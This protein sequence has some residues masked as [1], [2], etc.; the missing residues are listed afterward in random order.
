MIVDCHAHIGIPMTGTRQPL[1]YGKVLNKGRVEQWL[2]PSF[3]PTGSPPE[4][5][6]G[7]MDQAGV[8]RA[9]LVQ[10]QAY[11]DQNALVLDSIRRWPDRF[12]GFAYLGPLDRPEAPDRLERLIEAGMSGLKVIAMATR[13]QQPDFRFDGERE[14]RVWERLDRLKC[15]LVIDAMFAPAEDTE[16]IRKMVEEFG[17]LRILICHLGGPGQE[18]WQDRAMLAKHPRIW[19]DL[20]SIPGRPDPKEEYPYLNAQEMVRWAVTTFGVEKIMWGTDYP[21]ML[22]QGSYFQL[23]DY[24]RR[25]CSFLTA[26]EKAAILGGNTDRFV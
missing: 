11:G 12:Y 21:Q 2:P 17:N 24:V 6:L 18:G 5:L 7:H 20:S 15:P 4:V 26:E 23:L 19:V 9:F 8:D 22:R 1:R 10:A 16:A 13:E 3:D 14:W 25:H